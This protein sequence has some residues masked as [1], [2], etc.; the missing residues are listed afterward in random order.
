MA[1]ELHTMQN[2]ENVSSIGVS[3][4]ESNQTQVG[5]VM[6]LHCITQRVNGAFNAGHHRSS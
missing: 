4:S 1:T 5:T 3:D 2:I 6:V